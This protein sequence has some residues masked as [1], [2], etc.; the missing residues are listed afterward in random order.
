MDESKKSSKPIVNIDE[1]LKI[2]KS[3][4][5]N[6]VVLHLTA[7]IA[8]LKHCDHDQLINDIDNCISTA[9]EINMRRYNKE[10][11]IVYA[12][13]KKTYVKQMDVKFFKKCVPIF[14]TKHP[15]C[16]EKLIIVNMPV[17][18]KA[19]FNLIKYLIDKETRQK[20]Y[21][22]KKN[23]NNLFTNNLEEVDL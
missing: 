3:V 13:L 4:T 11:F 8:D 16:L 22:E 17:F 12:D 19:C 5:Y 18:F 20:I 7:S 9:R 10:K 2:K 21:F 1:L 23:S 6:S 15:D 14:E